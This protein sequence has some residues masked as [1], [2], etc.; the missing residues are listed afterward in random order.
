MVDHEE[1][2]LDTVRETV[3]MLRKKE[4]PTRTFTADG[5]S[6]TGWRLKSTES[7]ELRGRPGRGEFW[8]EYMER[9]DIILSVDGDFWHVGFWLIEGSQ[10]NERK[11]YAR[12]LSTSYFVGS[13]GKPFSEWQAKLE[14]LPYL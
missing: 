14:R 2:F 13:R 4:R 11:E 5:V 10:R 8:E 6:V 1:V 3:Q 7:D 9:G 12:P